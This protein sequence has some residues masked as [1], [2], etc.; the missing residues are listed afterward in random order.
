MNDRVKWPCSDRQKASVVWIEDSI[1]HN[2]PLTQNP[3]QSKALTLFNFKKTESGMEAAENS[4][5]GRG[6][7]I[8][9]K[10]RSHLHN[11]EIQ[12]EAASYPGN[13]VR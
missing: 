2:I 11:T 13:L 3:I 8:S 12:S 9:I 1:S 10:N 5:V 4:E 6:W 7:F